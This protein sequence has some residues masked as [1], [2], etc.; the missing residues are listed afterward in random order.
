MGFFIDEDT[1]AV[2][3]NFNNTEPKCNQFSMQKINTCI[4]FCT[5]WF[6]V[7]IHVHCTYVEDIQLKSFKWHITQDNTIW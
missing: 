1:I 4:Y 7:G 2:M 5:T 6:W 3:F